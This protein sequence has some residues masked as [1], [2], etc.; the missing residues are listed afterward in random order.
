MNTS[1]YNYAKQSSL[2]VSLTK[3]LVVIALIGILYSLVAPS[4]QGVI[5]RNRLKKAT[6]TVHIVNV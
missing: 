6:L 2:G 3:L 1:S 5:E 4:F